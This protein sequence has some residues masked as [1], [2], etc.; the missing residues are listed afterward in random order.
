MPKWQTQPRGAVVLHAPDPPSRSTPGTG[1]AGRE[2]PRQASFAVCTHRRGRRRKEADASAGEG[3][4]GARHGH[5]R[6]RGQPEDQ[7]PPV[8]SARERGQSP[9]TNGKW[10]WPPPTAAA[11]DSPVAA[12][13]RTR[14]KYATTSSRLPH[15]STER[16]LECIS[17]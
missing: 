2:G 5:G 9:G 10:R 1:R 14:S 15:D 8:T 11:A 12:C 6:G 17:A 13:P 16:S 7:A 3:L 4:V